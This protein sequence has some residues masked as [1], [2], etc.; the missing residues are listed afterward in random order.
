[1][2]FTEVIEQIMFERG[3]SHKE[4][5]SELGISTVQV[6]NL[7]TGIT[8]LPGERISNKIINYCEQHGIDIDINWNDVLYNIFSESEQYKGYTWVRD[9]D[10]DGYVVL[11]HKEC[12]RKTLVPRHSF[13]YKSTPCIHCWIDKYVSSEV[14]NV[15]TSED[16]FRHKFTH[17]CG[18][19][20]SV[21]Y[22]DIK[23]KKFRC[24]VCNGYRYNADNAN[25][26][27][28]ITSIQTGT[29]AR[30]PVTP[31]VPLWDERLKERIMDIAEEHGFS[32]EDRDTLHCNLFYPDMTS[33]QFAFICNTCFDSEI[34]DKNE[35]SIYKIIDFAVKHK[36]EC[37]E[38]DE[39]FLE[40]TKYQN[41]V[42]IPD[43]EQVLYMVALTVHG[44]NNLYAIIEKLRSEEYSHEVYV[45]GIPKQDDGKTVYLFFHYYKEN[46]DTDCINLLV[47]NTPRKF[48][49]MTFYA[50]PKTYIDCLYEQI[51][52]SMNQQTYNLEELQRSCDEY[53]DMVNYFKEHNHPIFV[54]ASLSKFSKNLDLILNRGNI[55]SQRQQEVEKILSVQHCPVCR[56]LHTSKAKVCIDCGFNELNKHFINKAELELWLNNVVIPARKMREEKN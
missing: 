28:R 23:Q 40:D 5:A 16:T 15:D 8:K 21:T 51:K 49:Q 32:V 25:R 7:R 17:K 34:F 1:M 31:I 55:I 43:V 3:L 12:G 36:H 56:N 45:A 29:S 35:S 13:G 33:K 20:Y 24:P 9:L 38:P 14:Y 39:C 19:S 50:L 44:N 4:L 10:E 26:N 27:R 6:E 2:I 18:H 22:E 48:S 41:I 53:I 52:L 30:P 54:Y 47:S 42:W 37:E 46:D 11:K